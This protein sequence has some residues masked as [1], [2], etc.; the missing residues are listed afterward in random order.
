MLVFFLVAREFEVGE[1]VTD[2]F[3][4]L[5]PE[6]NETVGILN[7][8]D[9]KWFLH[10]VGI[11]VGVVGVGIEGEMGRVGNDALMDVDFRKGDGWGFCF[12]NFKKIAIHVESVKRGLKGFPSF[13]DGSKDVLCLGTIE[14]ERRKGF[15]EQGDGRNATKEVLDAD[16][17]RF[18]I[19]ADAMGIVLGKCVVVD[20]L[21]LV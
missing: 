16:M 4:S 17:E 6:R 15:V 7:G 21:R 1:K 14:T 9:R 12:P 13:M 18:T 5:H 8:T 3:A 20:F 19:G 2:K 10:L 11:E